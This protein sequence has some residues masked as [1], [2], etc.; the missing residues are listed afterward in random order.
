MYET[1]Y[2]LKTKPFTLLPDPDFLYLSTKHR[3][4]LG[5]LEYG[6]TSSSPFSIITGNPGTG[7]T[8]LLHRLLDQSGHPW[9]VGMLSHVHDGVNGLMPWIAASFGLDTTGKSP[10]DLFQEFSRFLEREHSAARRVLLV[11][12]EAQNM[13]GVMLEELRLL[14]NLNDGRRRSLHI[15]LS[16]QPRLRELLVGPEMIQFAQRVGVEYALDALAEDEIGS[17][18][19]HRL[20]IAGRTVPLFSHL[21]NHT[22]FRL[23]GGLPRLVNQVCDHALVYGYAEQAERITSHI[24][25]SASAARAKLG[26][27]PLAASPGTITWSEQELRTE[28]AEVTPVRPELVVEAQEARPRSVLPQEVVHPAQAMVT[29][30]MSKGIAEAHEARASS[31]LLQGEL[32]TEQAVITTHTSKDIEGAGETMTPST[33]PHVELRA[34]QAALTARTSMDVEEAPAPMPSTMSSQ[35]QVRAE[36]TEATAV[37]PEEVITAPEQT[38]VSEHAKTISEDPTSTYR[39]GLALKGA[40]EFRQAIVVFERLIE[41]D[42]WAARALAQKGLCLIAVGRHEEAISAMWEASTKRSTNEDE[43]RTVQYL[44]ARTLES[45]GRHDEAR[46]IYLGLNRGRNPYRD[47]PARLARLPGG[48][49]VVEGSRAK[50]VVGLSAFKRGYEQL[51]RGFH[52]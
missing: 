21:A 9:T 22:V 12:D 49:P 27:L 38:P 43:G 40:K 20:Q 46:T 36:R 4:A 29:A 50:K 42:P 24:V 10:V 51:L 5:A 48:G 26:L 18:I 32:R 35:E 33:L 17:Y 7:K 47:V 23:T 41:R 6:L 16:G 1:Y 52:G 44:L 25:L 3:M 30:F 34:E 14:S 45:Q 19:A 28:Q 11:L 8:T 31:T 37:T 15:L 2:Q 39:E 13:S